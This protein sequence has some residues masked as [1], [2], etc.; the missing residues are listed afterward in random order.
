[1]GVEDIQMMQEPTNVH[2]WLYLPPNCFSAIHIDLN[3]H[4]IFLVSFCKSQTFLKP[5]GHA[6][7]AE[8][9]PSWDARLHC[10]RY[11]GAGVAGHARGP[12]QGLGWGSSAEK[13]AAK[14][15]T[16]GFTTPVFM[17]FRVTG[18]A[19]V[20]FVYLIWLISYGALFVE[21]R[22]TEA[23]VAFEEAAQRQRK[24]RKAV[25]DRKYTPAVADDMS[26]VIDFQENDSDA[27]QPRMG[28][29][30]SLVEHLKEQLDTASRTIIRQAMPNLGYI[31]VLAHYFTFA[32]HGKPRPTS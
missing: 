26:S 12:G 5:P 17:L 24:P 15:G 9:G 14:V 7:Q 25:A 16:R 32:C 4:C 22:T 27:Y 29:V 28:P 23:M 3:N 2:D 11:C 1:M 8:A 6:P 30:G 20:Y 31:H 18:L 13:G 10:R 21:F 19:K